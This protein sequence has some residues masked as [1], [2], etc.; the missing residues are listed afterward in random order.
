MLGVLSVCAHGITKLLLTES[1]HP[2]QNPMTNRIQRL[3]E[4]AI[5]FIK[6]V[7]ETEKQELFSGNSGG[8]DSAVLE[9]LLQTSGITYTSIHANT[10]IDP[11]GTIKHIRDNY[12]HTLIMQ[13]KETFYQ[14][15]ERKGFP[16]RL[17]RFCCEVLKEYTSIGKIMFEGVRSA[18]SKGRQGRDY[19]QC[20]S[21]KIMKGLNTYILFTI[22]LIMMFGIL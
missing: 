1:P 20:D 10:T 9:W 6:L 18:E 15:I 14:L 7:A 13:P 3:T 5:T 19:I 17:R 11:K 2:K 22:G 8:K 16:S 12:P 4:Q 21:R